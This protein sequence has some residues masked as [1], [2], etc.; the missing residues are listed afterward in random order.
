M[1]KIDWLHH[2]SSNQFKQYL[3]EIEQVNRPLNDE[4]ILAVQDKL[5][6]QGFQYLRVDSIQEGRQIIRLFLQS[7]SLYHAIGCLTLETAPQEAAS[8][9]DHLELCFWDKYLMQEYF[10]NFQFDFMW[11]EATEEMLSN[12]TFEQ[13]RQAMI[14]SMIDRHMT[15]LVLVYGNG[16]F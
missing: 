3:H 14:Q 6:S 2:A 10:I 5:L 13:I 12:P 9:Y 11:I 7:L 16:G 1:R 8:I 4:C 15:I